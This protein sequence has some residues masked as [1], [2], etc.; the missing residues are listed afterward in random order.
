MKEGAWPSKM[1]F[2]ILWMAGCKHVAYL[3]KRWYFNAVWEEGKLFR[4]CDAP[5]LF[6]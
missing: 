2:Y 1:F 6:C 3:G 5:S 4:Q